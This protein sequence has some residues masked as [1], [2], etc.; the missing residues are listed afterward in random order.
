MCLQMFQ[1]PSFEVLQVLYSDGCIQTAL[2]N[3]YG[4]TRAFT[5]SKLFLICASAVNIA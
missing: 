3:L 5:G 1:V 2:L 4:H